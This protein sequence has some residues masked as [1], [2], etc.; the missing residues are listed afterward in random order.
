MKEFRVK[1]DGEQA[2]LGKVPAADVA[3]ML[4]LVERAAAQAAAVVLRQPKTTTGRYKAVIE[5]AVHFRL[6][7]IVAGS[8]VPVLELPEAAPF[9]AEATLDLDVPDLGQSA[10]E[11]L[12]D[13]GEMSDDAD[14]GPADPVVANALLSVADGMYIGERYDSITFIVA[15][16]GAPSREVKIDGYVRRRLR[17]YVDSV[18]GPELREDDL[19]GVLFEADFEKRTA[20]LRTPTETSVE[21]SFLEAHDDA[22]QAALRQNS[23]VRGN[24][25]YDSR[26]H[27]AKSVRLTEI[28]QG[29]EQ[30]VLDPGE[31]WRALSFEDLA[32]RQGSGRPVDPGALYDDEA[33]DEERDSF[34]AA[35]AEIQ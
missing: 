20:R 24:V 28:V 27:V 12:L 10:L 19:V 2:Q 33:T 31:F 25:A 7:D 3:R 17:E 29:V 15:A 21:V 35:I 11:A 18:P 16:N 32:E 1:L 30:L 14:D 8:V 6:L 34:M 23:T 22:I 9:D 26:N 4:V 5:Q 13:A